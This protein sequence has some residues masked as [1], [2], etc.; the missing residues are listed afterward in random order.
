MTTKAISARKLLTIGNPKTEKGEKLGY[1]TAVLHLAPADL[2]GFEVCA[3]RTVGC[4]N[5]CLNT[6]GRG[7]IA[8]G[9]GILT[10]DSISA[11]KRNPVQEARIARTQWLFNDRTGFMAQL[12]KEIGAFVAKARKAG[13][14]PAIR[15]NA[16]SD[17][18]WEAKPFHL[19]GRSIME[20]FA[21]VTFYDYTKL[22]NRKGVPA[23]Y[24]LTFSLADG[25]AAKAYEA[26][27]NGFNVA[28]VFRDIETRDYYME[29][30]FMGRPV[31]DGDETDLRFLD[32]KVSIV[33]LY[34]KGSAKRDTSGFVIDFPQAVAL[35][36]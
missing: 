25:N 14:I 20:W 10:Y 3:G 1:W 22:S 33:G 6:S 12:F 30:G 24:H 11:G 9:I 32:P 36:A 17:I 8:A 2:S 18:R 5:G 15:L 26:L 28:A 4:T 21:D 34:A 29:T 16:T 23:N 27:A 31:I 13:F 19:D 7:G 35:A